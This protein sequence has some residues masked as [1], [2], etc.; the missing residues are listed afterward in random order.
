MQAALVVAFLLQPGAALVGTLPHQLLAKHQH[1][2]WKTHIY[3]I[4]CTHLHAYTNHL[5]GQS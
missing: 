4:L 1:I 2:S 5:L 3:I